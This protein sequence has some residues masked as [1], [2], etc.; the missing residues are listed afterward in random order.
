MQPRDYQQATLDRVL[1]EKHD[2]FGLFYEQRTGKTP[3]SLF[4]S[5]DWDCHHNLVVCPKKAIPVWENKIS[6][7]GLNPQ[8]WTIITYSRARIDR[9]SL[10]KV[11]WDLV[12]ADESH[13]IKERSSSQTKA[14][15]SI[16]RRAKKRLALSGSPQGDGLEDYYGQLRF[17]RPDLFPTW[18][19]FSERF[20]II[21]NL[22]I[23]GRSDTETFPKIVGYRNEDKFKEILA[24]ISDRVERSQVSTVKILIRTRIHL[25]P[26]TKES[27]DHYD[28]LDRD[29]YT[30]I[31]GRMASTPIV[32]TK[33][34][35]L[36]QLCGGFLK[37]DLGEVHRVG[38]EKLNYLARLLK[39]NKESVVIVCQYKKEMDT[40]ALL[41]ESLGASYVQIRGRH[42]YDPN[43]RSQYTI[44]NCASGEAI[45]LS[46][47]TR[48]IVY[49]M[50]YSFLK[51]AQFKDRIVLVDTPEVRYDYLIMEDS[52]DQIVYDAVVKK[53]KLAEAVTTIYKVKRHQ[54]K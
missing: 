7:M 12:I 33:A 10:S 43:D 4:L 9:V 26:W 19:D 46:H 20:L 37:D 34:S 22:P 50:N 32:L 44:L 17:I 6:E 24:S 16:G 45:E 49:S 5:R 39:D 52:M 53:K 25:I 40:V 51:W 15:W 28:R 21:K 35:K 54:I 42:Q 14:L 31:Q 2:G 48:M 47:S 36:H 27:R 38:G 11:R 41:L 3:L 1:L 29:L 18:K 8:E 13:Y 30:T 23:P